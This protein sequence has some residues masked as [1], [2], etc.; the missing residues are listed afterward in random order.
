MTFAMVIFRNSS[1][2]NLITD[3]N[4]YPLLN[5][6]GFGVFILRQALGVPEVAD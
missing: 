5:S 1:F 3:L 2:T 4:L 6:N